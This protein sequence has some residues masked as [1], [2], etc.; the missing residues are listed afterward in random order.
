MSCGEFLRALTEQGAAADPAHAG[1]CPRCAQALLELP[2]A[3]TLCPAR[4]TAGIL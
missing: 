4:P 2:W 1:I 3:V